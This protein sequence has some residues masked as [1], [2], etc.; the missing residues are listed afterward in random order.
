MDMDTEPGLG[1]VVGG[2]W[3]VVCG[4]WLLLFPAPT[5]CGRAKT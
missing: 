4:L 2:L 5:V 1:A 3:S